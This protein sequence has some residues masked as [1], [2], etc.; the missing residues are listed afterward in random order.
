MD[1]EHVYRVGEQQGQSRKPD[2]ARWRFELLALRL[3]VHGPEAAEVRTIRSLANSPLCLETRF[4]L[5]GH[6]FTDTDIA[7]LMGLAHPRGC[8]CWDCV[9]ALRHAIIASLP[10]RRAKAAS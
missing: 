4:L 1:Q 6:G 8:A 2:R 3:D 5:R 7:E 10:R 9:M